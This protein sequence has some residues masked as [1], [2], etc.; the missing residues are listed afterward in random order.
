MPSSLLRQTKSSKAQKQRERERETATRAPCRW[1]TPITGASAHDHCPLRIIAPPTP[2]SFLLGPGIVGLVTYR[3]QSFRL[4]LSALAVTRQHRSPSPCRASRSRKRNHP[5][6][7]HAC[8][9]HRRVAARPGEGERAHIVRL[10]SSPSDTGAVKEC[11]RKRR[12]PSP[13]TDVL[14]KITPRNAADVILIQ[15][16][17][18]GVVSVIAGPRAER[19]RERERFSHFFQVV[20]KLPQ[21]LPA[22]LLGYIQFV[23]NSSLKPTKRCSA[24]LRCVFQVRCRGNSPYG[25]AAKHLVHDDEYKIKKEKA[26][27][28]PDSIA[29][30][31]TIIKDPTSRRSRRCS[32]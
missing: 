10:R 16:R 26:C 2:L 8:Y 11:T 3:T 13:A 15:G 28:P 9:W 23:S 5:P 20:K 1:Q 4:A 32:S 22:C 24:V 30:Q 17:A 6:S 18:G 25:H 29:T 27:G 21:L 31:K 14:S 12:L 7:T 19:E